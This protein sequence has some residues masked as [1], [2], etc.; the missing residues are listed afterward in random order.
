MKKT[1]LS[2]KAPPDDIY[3][4]SAAD[5]AD[6]IIEHIWR[7]SDPLQLRNSSL[8]LIP[9]ASMLRTQLRRKLD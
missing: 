7:G 3:Q 8:A 1:A 4:V 6:K 2:M 5:I 9:A